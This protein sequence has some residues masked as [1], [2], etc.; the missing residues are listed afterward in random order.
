M[1][2]KGMQFKS[3]CILYSRK[4]KFTTCK[5]YLNKLDSNTIDFLQT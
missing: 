4:G 2:V 3:H 1:L 5:L